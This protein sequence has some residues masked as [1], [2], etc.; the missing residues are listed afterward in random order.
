MFL[1]MDSETGGLDP[2]EHSILTLYMAIYDS[3]FNKISELD[4]KIK[5][6][7]GQYFVTDDAM[8]VNGIDLDEHDK[9]AII[10]LEASKQIQEFLANHSDDGKIK[11]MPF[12]HNVEF[13]VQFVKTKLIPKKIWDK[14]CT[15]NHLDTI[16]IGTFLKII[17]GLPPELPNS[18]GAYAEFF[19]ISTPGLHDAKIDC[20]TTVAVLKRMSK[21]ILNNRK[22]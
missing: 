22:F 10:E 11:L 9:N 14:T 12:G 20:M 7:N 21:F 16:T 1:L 19:G 8:K 17:G 15:Y 3:G 4:L 18:L 5:P 6:N 2:S 13:D